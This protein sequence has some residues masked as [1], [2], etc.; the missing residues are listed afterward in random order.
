MDK[1]GEKVEKYKLTKEQLRFQKQFKQLQMIRQLLQ[2][3]SLRIQFDANNNRQ[4]WRA[5]QEKAQQLPIP[6]HPTNELDGMNFGE[7][8]LDYMQGRK[9]AGEEMEIRY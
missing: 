9:Q 3:D 6:R 5:L 1:V 4:L 8:M 2:A 7:E